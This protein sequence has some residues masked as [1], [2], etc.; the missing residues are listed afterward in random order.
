MY[1]I[2]VCYPQEDRPEYIYQPATMRSASM[3][4]VFI[5]GAAMEK[6]RDG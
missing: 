1:S 4:K 3:I 5:L 2:Y 6:I